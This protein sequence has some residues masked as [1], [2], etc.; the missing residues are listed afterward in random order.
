MIRKKSRSLNINGIKKKLSRFTVNLAELAVDFSLFPRDDEA[1]ALR[2]RR[3]L[4]LSE[5]T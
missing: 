5:F 4:Y 1:Q 2:L 3:F